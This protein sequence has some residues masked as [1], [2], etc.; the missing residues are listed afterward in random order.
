MCQAFDGETASS[1]EES[2]PPPTSHE[3]VLFQNTLARCGFAGSLPGV[4]SL[5]LSSPD[6]QCGAQAGVSSKCRREGSVLH[7]CNSS[8]PRARSRTRK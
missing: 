7:K 6:V 2:K 1:G 4:N 5:P 8:C 3:L